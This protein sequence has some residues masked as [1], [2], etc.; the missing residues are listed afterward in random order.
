MAAIRWPSAGRVSG[1]GTLRSRRA[2]TAAAARPAKAEVDAGGG[3]FAV[4]TD[5][6]IES[7]WAPALAAARRA[8]LTA[9]VCHNWRQSL[10]RAP[11]LG[12]SRRDG[13]PPP[14]AR[15]GNSHSPVDTCHGR[16]TRR[17]RPG[18]RAAARRPARLLR[19]GPAGRARAEPAAARRRRG[20]AGLGAVALG[21][22]EGGDRRLCRRRR[23]AARQ[24][25]GSVPRWLRRRALSP[26]VHDRG[27]GV[28]VDERGARRVAGARPDRPRPRADA[29]Q[30][31]HDGGLR[32]E[33]HDDRRCPAGRARRAHRRRRRR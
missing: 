4:G 2:R 14:F 32:P 25:R 22:A 19:R 26:R 12:R 5:A 11:G 29:G 33:R 23:L 27:H 7:P 18:E 21:H 13:S 17:P 20:G 15:F 6:G 9:P 3:S 28:V 1:P 16:F 8:G 24:R 31:L 10:H 30:P